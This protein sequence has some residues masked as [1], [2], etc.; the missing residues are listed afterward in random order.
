MTWDNVQQIARILAYGVSGYLVNAGQLDPA[1]GETLGG[2]LLGLLSVAWWFF[3]NRK[4]E[5]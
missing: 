4:K 2:A 3:W 5:A 1:N